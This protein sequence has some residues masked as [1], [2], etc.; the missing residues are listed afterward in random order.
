[1]KVNPV[2]TNCLSGRFLHVCL[3]IS[4]PFLLPS[5]AAAANQA[6]SVLD[7]WSMAGGVLA[8]L[9]LFLL[10][11]EHLSVGL[12][13]AAGERLK[14][15]LAK[16]TDNPIRGVLTGAFVTAIIQSSSVTT[17]LV[18]G[19]INA[20][21]MTLAQSVG[22]IMGANIGATITAQLVAFKVT[23]A[24]NAL[25][26]VGFSMTLISKWERIKQ[27]GNMLLGLGL[28]FFG[29]NVMG[30]AMGPLRTYQPFINLMAGMENP[31]V[32]IA[33]AALFTALIQS[34]SAVT[35]IVIVMAGQ[36]LVTLPA[37]IALIFGADIGTC[38]TALLA[39]IGKQREA[40]RGALV[41]ILFNVAG[42]LLF[43]GFIDHFGVLVSWLSPKHPELSG[44]QKAIAEAPR[45][46]ANAHTVFRII[47]TLVFIGFTERIAQIATWL[48]PDK[49][50]AVRPVAEPRY[51]HDELV[52]TPSLALDR[53]RMELDRLGGFVSAML[54]AIIP[55]AMEGDKAALSKVKR[56]DEDV[57]ALY[58]HI[59]AYM[60]KLSR[61]LLTARQTSDLTTLM[62]AANYMEGM[63]DVVETNLVGL[64]KRRLR[65][66][67]HVSAETYGIIQSFHEVVTKA[68]D[69][70]VK[71]VANKDA[72]AAKNVINMKHEINQLE[73]NAARHEANRLIAE[74]PNRVAAYAFEMDFIDNLK[75][76]YQ[77]ARRTAKAANRNF[78]DKSGS[79]KK[80]A[81]A[82]DNSP[83]PFSPEASPE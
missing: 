48:L 22:V 62:A 75:R 57:D 70:A 31:F 58:G 25:L 9:A 66:G 72:E 2:Q 43:V 52:K 71:A 74:A 20:G 46:L 13:A 36:G 38:V 63:G 3:F 60:A 81:V 56:M 18:V 35:G 44:V 50:C 5:F 41:H 37:G 78:S 67:V 79:L 53:V 12:K 8:G 64:G 15:I 23:S 21:L 27:Y 4:T 59:V 7:R 40:V 51:L 45:Q 28:V 55:A 42:V 54:Y 49:I 24:A 68:V 65:E 34:S 61:G 77:S 14:L 6:A 19:F 82:K 10:G 33:A 1:M 47:T 83:P 11:M 30:A 69:L 32:G 26:A 73:K 29:I 39:S 17:T 76:I 16:I 80:S